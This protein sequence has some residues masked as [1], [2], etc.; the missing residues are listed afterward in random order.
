MKCQEKLREEELKCM[1]NLMFYL[2]NET[3]ENK[4]SSLCLNFHLIKSF[5]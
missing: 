1:N 5:F 3:G 2:K 4:H